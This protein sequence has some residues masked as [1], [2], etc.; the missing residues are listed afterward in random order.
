[1]L[2]GKTQ[3]WTTSF[4]RIR[5]VKRIETTWTQSSADTTTA[6]FTRIRRVKR[7]ETG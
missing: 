3:P 2:V 5:R 4:T 6:C 1:M 7:I